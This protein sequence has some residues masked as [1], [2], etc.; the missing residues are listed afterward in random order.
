MFQN[1]T[2]HTR[3]CKNQKKIKSARSCST[4]K[5]YQQ[6]TDGKNS[7]IRQS[8]LQSKIRQIQVM[9]KSTGL[10]NNTGYEWYIGD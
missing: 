5:I 9:G 8:R 7:K 10:I 4:Q 2:L 6:E 1:Y 3:L